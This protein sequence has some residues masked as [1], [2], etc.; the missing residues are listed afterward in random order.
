ME[1][2]ISVNENGV[3]KPLAESIL[4][5]RQIRYIPWHT[6]YQA[7]TGR[8]CAVGNV[9]LFCTVDLGFTPDYVLVKRPTVNPILFPNDSHSTNMEYTNWYYPA[10]QSDIYNY[11]FHRI[12]VL[13][14]VHSRHNM[15][16]AEADISF[17]FTY[18]VSNISGSTSTSINT[19]FELIDNTVKCYFT[20]SK[21]TADN[22]QKITNG[23]GF[24]YDRSGSKSQYARILQFEIE[25]FGNC[26][27]IAI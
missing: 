26:Q 12:I 11:G 3:V 27:P 22:A 4:Y 21:T 16:D 19:G 9:D 1:M 15:S 14:P 5:E 10:G 18:D 6:K 17:T 13:T 8:D 7:L 23:I 24:G 20:H 2:P 25:A